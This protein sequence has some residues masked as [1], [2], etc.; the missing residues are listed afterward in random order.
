MFSLNKLIVKYLRELADKFEADTTEVTESQAIDILR[1]IAHEAMSKEQA[2]NFLNLSRSRFDELVRTKVLPKG[3]KVVGL[4]ELVW[5]KD[6][7]EFCKRK[8]RK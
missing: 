1:V 8:D 2:C 6:E 7:L 3:N 4:K 5:W